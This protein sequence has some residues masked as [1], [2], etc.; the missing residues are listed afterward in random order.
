MKRLAFVI[1]TLI[2]ASGCAG[3]MSVETPVIP[4]N[5][6]LRQ[7]ILAYIALMSEESTEEFRPHH[8]GDFDSVQYGHVSRIFVAETFEH[9]EYVS[10]NIV[11]GRMGD[12]ARPISE[13]SDGLAGANI[14]SLEI[15]EVISGDLEVGE[16]I[17]ILEPYFVQ[18]GVLY[19]SQNYLPSIPYQEYIFFL[20]PRRTEP[21]LI[22]GMFW[23]S[24]GERGRYPMPG[25]SGPGPRTQASVMHY[26]GDDGRF[27]SGTQNFGSAVFGLGSHANVE[28][29]A[30]I[31]EEVMN[32]YVLP[33]LVGID[34]RP[35]EA[36]LSVGET[37]AITAV[38]LPAT[39]S[40]ATWVSSNPGVATVNANGVVTAVS[41]GATTITATTTAG[42]QATSQILVIGD[43]MSIGDV[44]GDGVVDF[45]D[46]LV[47]IY[48]LDNNGNI[49]PD[50]TFVREN[51]DLNGDGVIDDLD[52]ELL[53]TF[54]DVLGMQ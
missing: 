8:Y 45:L 23:V 54:L 14:V 16:T 50:V 48:Y 11:R 20:R 15:L 42:E 13:R 43:N 2:F 32:E 18:G 51:A 40:V 7:S 38:V 4:A 22:A 6:E 44:N 26:L 33:T 39:D 5:Y 34:L 19:T 36:I 53:M 17:T 27:D 10:R 9:L 41:V 29:Y 3:S 52:L 30:S 12:D 24:H 28:V 37:L 21:E 35:G 47:L 1:A 46:L 31:W 49:S 25:P